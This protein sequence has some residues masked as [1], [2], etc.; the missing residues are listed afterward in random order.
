MHAWAARHARDPISVRPGRLANTLSTTANGHDVAQSLSQLDAMGLVEWKLRPSDFRIEWLEPRRAAEHV[1]VDRSRRKV[2]EH[3]LEALIHY[4]H[5]LECRASIIDSHFSGM[6]VAP[7]GQCDT[8]TADRKR[9][10]KALLKRLA[11]GPT[12]GVELLQELRPGHRVL[13]RKVLQHWLKAGA[14][15]ANSTL[16]KWVGTPPSSGRENT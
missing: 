6:E 15:E 1:V 11:T 3:S 12:S 8:C 10:R 14:L 16:L 13:A 7:C 2:V 4:V 9:I 5:G